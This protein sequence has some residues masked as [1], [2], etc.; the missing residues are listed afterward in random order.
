MKTT[1]KAV[2]LWA[3]MFVGALVAGC[4]STEKQTYT[5]LEINLAH[6]NDHHSHLDEFSGAELSIGG[7]RTQLPLGGF[8]RQVA[9]FKAVSGLPNLVKIHAGDALT[10]TQYFTLFQGKADAQMMNNICFDY[11]TL[12]NHEFDSSD[13]V[14]QSF[15]TEL[16]G[17]A[18][19]QP[20]VVVSSNVQPAARTPLAPATNGHLVPWHVREIDGVRVGFIGITI[21]GKTVNASRPLPSTNFL[22][23]AKAAQA[24]IDALKAQGVRHIVAVTHQG[25]ENDKALAAQ[26]TDVDVIIGGDSHSLLGDFSALGVSSSGP[27]PTVARNKSGEP[28]CIGQAWEYG[29]A[30]GLMRVRFD[31]Q[32]AV[33]SC[34]GEVKLLVG[35]SFKRRDAKGQWVAVPEA[36]RAA[37]RTQLQGMKGV[38][39]IAP[40]AEAVKVLKGYADRIAVEKAKLIGKA[41]ES[42]CL[43][44]V[45]GETTNRSASV[46]GCEQANRLARG[47]DAAQVVAQAFLHASKTSQIALQNSGGVRVPVPA[48]TL[49]MN[50]AYSVLP[51]SNVLVE[52]SMT[53]AELRSALEDAVSNYLENKLSDGSHPYAAGLRWDL[54]LSQP[55]GQRFT[56]LQVRD[57]SSGQWSALEP[58][59][60]YTVVTNDFIASGKDGYA[61]LGKVYAAGRYTET[62]LLY[63]QSLVDYMLAQQEL[64]RPA[65]GEYSHQRVVSLAG[66]VLE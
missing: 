62:Y 4:A 1:P 24:A 59:R 43:V 28:V 26:L 61:T 12:G 45:P 14:L 37:L 38:S 42:L 53:G 20:S 63:T 10:G 46:A 49:T 64:R 25:Y 58:Q 50:S 22:P 32:G 18:C 39:V 27:Y 31:A 35:D 52:L 15:L 51:F 13:A 66:A 23:E 36:E 7:A 57:R 21:V 19:P 40:D 29:K 41:S 11:F 3:L 47:S 54:D 55:R 8:A 65:R 33:E 44:R 17:G 2:N 30:F 9:A 48:G 34:G 60:T 16:R 5:P 6:I 56:N